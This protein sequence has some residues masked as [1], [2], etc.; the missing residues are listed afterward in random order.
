MIEVT[1]PFN[2]NSDIDA[3]KLASSLNQDI[4][5][6]NKIE[7]FP[8][9]SGFGR[10]SSTSDALSD[11]LRVIEVK[12]DNVDNANNKIR[13]GGNN[14]NDSCQGDSGGPLSASGYFPNNIQIRF[15]Y[16][17]HIVFV[18]HQLSTFS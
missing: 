6:T 7:G 11:E 4:W 10:T 14:G 8:I 18:I 15:R 12:V 9:V 1:E 16:F 13:A 2:F 3:V 5:A 17:L